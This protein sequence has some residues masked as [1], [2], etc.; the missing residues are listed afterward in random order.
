MPPSSSLSIRRTVAGAERPAMLPLGLLNEEVEGD[1]ESDRDL[2]LGCML[3][4]TASYPVFGNVQHTPTLPTQYASP[5]SASKIARRSDTFDGSC[6]DRR[7]ETAIWELR[8]LGEQTSFLAAPFNNPPENTQD[9][10]Y[11]HIA[12][13]QYTNSSPIV[14]RS[15]S[16]SSSVADFSRLGR[17]PPSQ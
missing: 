2:E 7:S 3:T 4:Q 12:I 1:A 6:L 14:P 10:L 13:Y 9:M 5:F 17:V 16:A 11:C 8:D 15:T